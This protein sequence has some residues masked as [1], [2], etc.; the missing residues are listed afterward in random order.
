ET[1]QVNEYDGRRFRT[2]RKDFEAGD[3][4]EERHFYYTPNWRCLEERLDSATTPDRQFVWGQRY[5]DDLIVRY[6][7]GERQVAMQDAN[8]NGT[9]IADATGT[10]QERYAYTA[11]GVPLFLDTDFNILSATL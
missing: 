6:R 3:L 1:V 8:W 2:I 4:A 7:T 9:A 11:Y 5:I 10:V